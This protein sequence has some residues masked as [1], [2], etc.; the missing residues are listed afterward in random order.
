MAVGLH[1]VSMAYGRHLALSGV[2]LTVHAGTATALVGPNGSGKTT[3]LHLIAGLLTPTSGRIDPAPPTVAYVLQHPGSG[4][5]MPLTVSE[6]LHMGRYRGHRLIGRLGR[7]D[8]AAI[9]EAAGR[10]AVA[11]LVDRQ[12]GELSGGQRQRVLV[13]QALAQQAPVVLMDEPITGLDL[14]SQQRILDVID[15]E[16]ARGTAVVLSTHHLDEA[17]HCDQV[18]L[19]AR[20]LVAAGPPAEVLRPEVLRQAYEDHLFNAHADHDHPSGLLLIDEHGHDHDVP[21]PE[22]ERPR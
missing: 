11:D 15:Q 13:A 4:N 6:V 21:R 19:F 3:L 17:H 10:L 1:D 20:R 2:D 7:R 9:D 5:W 8:L 22:A 12:F 18:A 14:D 16:T